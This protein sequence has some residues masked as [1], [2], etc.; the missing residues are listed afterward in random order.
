MRRKIQPLQSA[1]DA[2]CSASSRFGKYKTEEEAIARPN[3]ARAG[4]ELGLLIRIWKCYEGLHGSDEMDSVVDDSLSDPLAGSYRLSCALLEG[5][6]FSAQSI[7]ALSIA[8]SGVSRIE[9]QSAYAYGCFFSALVNL[10]RASSYRLDVR[11]NEQPP[12]ALCFKN[13]KN[14]TV[15]GDIGESGGARMESGRV[16]I[17]GSAHMPICEDMEGGLFV[18]NGD[19]HLDPEGGCIVGDKM[20]GGEIRLNGNVV[21]ADSD[22]WVGQ[23]RNRVIH[24]RIFHKGKLIADK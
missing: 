15:L 11:Q 21:G 18:L 8:L 3:S 13:R 19:M 23:I 20:N 22:G 5:R 14:V 7:E 6:R 4:R 9:E 2:Q 12:N 16:V 24:G 17:E 10:G 1:K